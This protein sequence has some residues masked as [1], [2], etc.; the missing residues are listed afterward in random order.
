MAPWGI[1]TLGL[2]MLLAVFWVARQR[3]RYGE[4]A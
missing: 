2:L 3:M 1:A 4:P